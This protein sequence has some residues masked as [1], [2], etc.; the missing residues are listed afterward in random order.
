M[1]GFRETLCEE[2][3]VSREGL[4]CIKVL[5]FQGLLYTMFGNE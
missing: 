1:F 5:E 2:H 3:G 4:I